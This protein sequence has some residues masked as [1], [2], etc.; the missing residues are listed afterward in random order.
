M[1]MRIPTIDCTFANDAALAESFAQTVAANLRA[2]IDARGA[3]LIGLSG[4]STPREF[5]KHL[6]NQ[7]LDWNRVTVTLCDDRWVPPTSDRSNERFLRETLLLNKAAN[8]RFVPLHIDGP[9]PDA[10]L[11]RVQ[12]NL[13]KLALPFDVIV[14]GMGSDGHTASLFPGGDRLAEATNPDTKT[15]ALP[16][17][18]PDA[19]EP[20]ITLTLPTLIDTR[21]LYLHIEGADKKSVFDQAMTSDDSP[22]PIR[23]VLKASRVTPIVYWCP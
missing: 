6:S 8:V 4:G 20:R 10:A 14:L 21:A 16:M 2:G 12:A 9:D 1:T 17:R 23:T 3:A 18:A 7:E 11:P 15:R 22:A 13:A 19:S 5:L